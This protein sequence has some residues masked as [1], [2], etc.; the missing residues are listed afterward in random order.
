MGTILGCGILTEEV[1]QVRVVIEQ[2]QQNGKVTMQC[3]PL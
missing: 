1:G 2:Y 3:M